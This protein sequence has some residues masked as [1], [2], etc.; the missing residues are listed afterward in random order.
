MSSIWHIF[1]HGEAIVKTC[2]EDILKT[3]LL[4]RKQRIVT[5][6][7]TT[8]EYKVFWFFFYLIVGFLGFF[9][10]EKIVTH[11]KFAKFN[12]RVYILFTQVSVLLNI[13]ILVQMSFTRSAEG[14][15]LTFLKTEITGIY[16]YSSTVFH[17][18]I[19]CVL[20]LF[21]AF[22]SSVEKLYK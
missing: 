13:P 1:L 21:S 6:F 11:V 22:S 3:L 16:W 8:Q 18:I 5:D 2:P 10:W 4:I 20:Q 15:I 7:K 19:T 14:L 9:C 17:S 12:F